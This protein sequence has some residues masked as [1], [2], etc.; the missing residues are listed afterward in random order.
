MNEMMM[1]VTNEVK[2]NESSSFWVRKILK[3]VV[4][5]VEESKKVA[6]VFNASASLKAV[7]VALSIELR[8]L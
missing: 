1:V 7:S 3:R 6:D 5:P 8:A 4:E 2:K